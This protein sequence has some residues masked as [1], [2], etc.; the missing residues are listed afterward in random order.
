MAKYYFH[1][2]TGGNYEMDAAGLDL[3]SAESAY[4]EA[5][6]AAQDLCGEL[7][8]ERCAPATYRFEVADQ[9]GRKIFDLPF[10][11][12]IEASAPRPLPLKRG[13]ASSRGRLESATLAL[14]KEIERVQVTMGKSRDALTRSRDG[15]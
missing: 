10:S 4:L 15:K 11:E 12:I 14:M 5:Y 2:W 13:S 3:E 6:R 9:S 1:L 7:I 8:R